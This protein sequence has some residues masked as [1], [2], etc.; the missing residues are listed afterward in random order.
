MCALIGPIIEEQKFGV[1]PGIL[2][3]YLYVSR[4][5]YVSQ[6]SC[7]FGHYIL[8]LEWQSIVI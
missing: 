1:G 6:F 2:F 8:E 7:F 4:F 3:L 5:Q